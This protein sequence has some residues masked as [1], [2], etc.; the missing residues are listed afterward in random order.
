MQANYDIREVGVAQTPSGDS[1]RNH[2][3]LP[4]QLLASS[5]KPEWLFSTDWPPTSFQTTLAIHPHPTPPQTP[6][7]TSE[8][9]PHSNIEITRSCISIGRFHLLRAFVRFLP[10]APRDRFGRQ[11][12]C[13][14]PLKNGRCC[15]PPCQKGQLSRFIFP[16]SNWISG[17]R[18]SALSRRR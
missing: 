9:F 16:P 2:P 6:T 4:T 12:K 3:S 15:A 11:I 7:W 1:P 17:G 13:S 18:P 5:R 8:S 14:H 10:S